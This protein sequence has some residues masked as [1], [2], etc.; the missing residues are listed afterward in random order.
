MS[1][2]TEYVFLSKL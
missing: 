2:Q 1:M